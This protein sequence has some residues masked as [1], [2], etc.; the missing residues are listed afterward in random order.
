MKYLKIILSL[1]LCALGLFC[2]AQASLQI[3]GTPE[4]SFSYLRWTNDDHN[5]LFHRY[6]LI[7]NTVNA[8]DTVSTIIERGEIWRQNYLFVHPDYWL[9]NDTNVYFELTLTAVDQNYLDIPDE[10]V[11]SLLSRR[12]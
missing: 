6:E 9:N 1:W 2:T 7:K 10:I 12:S 3:T 5:V 8:I 11:T 4:N